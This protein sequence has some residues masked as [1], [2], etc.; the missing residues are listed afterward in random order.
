MN[1]KDFN[2]GYVVRQK[3][4]KPHNGYLEINGTIIELTKRG[5]SKN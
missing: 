4:K 3:Y 1:K 2:V 5:T